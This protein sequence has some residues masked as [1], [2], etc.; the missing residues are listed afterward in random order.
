MTAK[1]DN[2][3]CSVNVGVKLACT[4]CT[5]VNR[6]AVQLLVHVAKVWDLGAYGYVKRAGHRCCELDNH[7]LIGIGHKVLSCVLNALVY[8]FNGYNTRCKI[9][10]SVVIRNLVKWVAEI[11][12]E[13][14]KV[15][16]T[17]KALVANALKVF[18]IAV[19]VGLFGELYSLGFGSAEYYRTAVS[20]AYRH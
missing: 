3:V 10:V 12:I 18:V 16:Y 5:V 2:A 15:L 4:E 13:V 17:A 19:A 7:C 14:G 20:V 11:K 1:V 8:V 9:E 6:L